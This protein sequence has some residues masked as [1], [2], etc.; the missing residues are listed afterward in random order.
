MNWNV[1]LSSCKQHAEIRPRN[2]FINITRCRYRY[3]GNMWSTAHAGHISQASPR[4]LRADDDDDDCSR[5]RISQLIVIYGK[6]IG[7]H[8]G[9]SAFILQ[10]CLKVDRNPSRSEDI[11]SNSVF[12]GELTAFQQT[13]TNADDR[14]LWD[15]R[16]SE[17][18]SPVL[19]RHWSVAQMQRSFSPHELVHRHRVEKSVSARMVLST[20][21][22]LCTTTLVYVSISYYV[23][24]TINILKQESCAICHRNRSQVRLPAT[25]C[26][27]SRLLE[28]LTVCGL[29]N[30]V[31]M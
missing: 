28:W 16:V 10:N 1:C 25:H 20:T 5:R 23:Q 26:W 17:L 3:S 19:Y 15:R 12:I 21:Q 9:S 2:Q 8:R 22:K 13:R 14:H 27:V 29:V 30:Y 7:V 4:Q 31:G 18:P 11:S 6:K 24:Q